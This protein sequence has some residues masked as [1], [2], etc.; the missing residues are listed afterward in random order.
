MKITGTQ[1]VIK[2][3]SSLAITIPAKEARHYGIK[4]GNT[5]SFG[6]DPI[7]TA[8]PSIVNEYAE[9]KAQY[10]KTLKNLSDR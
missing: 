10:A 8:P 9:F 7:D 5:V 4:V 1:N 3:G 6:I 2:V